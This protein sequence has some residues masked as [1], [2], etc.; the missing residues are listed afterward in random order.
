MDH[1]GSAPVHPAGVLRLAK[2][3]EPHARMHVTVVVRSRA[4][5]RQIGA[6]VAKLGRQLPARRLLP[7]LRE[8][9]RRYASTREDIARVA[10]FYESQDL[11]IVETSRRRRAVSLSGTPGQLSRAFGVELGDYE[12][13]VGRYLSHEGPVSLP[14]DLAGTIEGVLGLDDRP[15]HTPHL[16]VAFRPAEH[17]T[18]ALEVSK[19]Y[20]FPED[21]DGR[22]QTIGILCL[23][24]GFHFSDVSAYF[25]RCGLKQ[26]RITVVELFG[27]K[28]SPAPRE[29]L[30]GFA[31]KL[32]RGDTEG[33]KHDPHAMQ[34]MWTI[35]ATMDVELAAT[36]APGAHIVVYFAPNNERGRFSGLSRA[37]AD[38]VHRPSIFSYSWGA[39]ED[40][41]ARQVLRVM[42]RC[43][44]LAALRGV[45][46]CVSSGD[47]GRTRVNF[48]ASSPHVLACGG[49]HLHIDN[50]AVRESVWNETH[51]SMQMSSSGGFSH[52]FA[53]PAWQPAALAEKC[54]AKG[55]RGV[56]DVAA[57][58]DLATG[59]EIV[60]GNHTVPM[61]GTS[62]A[63]PLWAGLIARLNQKLKARVGYLSPLLYTHR[64][65]QATHDITA[66]TNGTYN[67]MPGWDP[68]TGKGAPDGKA[69]LAA[70]A[71]AKSRKPRAKRAR[72]A[73]AG[74]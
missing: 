61:G 60:A 35:E 2:P 32:E 37:L 5:D 28:N 66:G 27:A 68:C 53:C 19:I 63:A 18:H 50:G 56:P 73:R 1:P 4:S 74:K 55:G 15:L 71:G 29:T 44:E 30:A 17:Y 10:A 72:M 62:A 58:A 20:N 38:T 23:G 46:I 25:A 45:T 57:K 21:A 41:I 31:R 47:S 33:M 70:L 11:R 3:P 8:F 12:N 65:A 7:D 59:Y 49:T 54:G 40:S 36:F 14:R 34:I 26:P 22:G 52:V 67:A 43:Y 51:G 42:D 6:A 48:P 16:A 69:L 13:A 24:G 9:D 64:F 39:P